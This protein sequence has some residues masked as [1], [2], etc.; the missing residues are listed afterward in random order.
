MGASEPPGRALLAAGTA[1][2]DWPDFG[3]LE[4]VPASLHAIVDALTGLGF[5]TVIE[6]PGYRVDPAPG[7]LRAAVRQAAAAAP[8]VVLYYTGHGILPERDGYYLV[9][10]RTRLTDM[11][12]TAMPAADIPRLLTRRDENGE[13][14]DDQP[15]V[16]VILDCCYSGS[17]GMEM[18]GH[19]LRGIG[20][21][22][23]W[24]IASVSAL[25]YA[26]QGR[27]A[28]AFCDAI[29]R[30][31][32]G[33]STR[34]LSLESVIQ[35]VNDAQPGQPEQ[36]ARVFPP[37]TG[38]AGI[39]P[40]F[41]NR[42]YWPGLAGLTVSEQHWLSRVRG[43]PQE[44]TTG[45]YLTGRTGR[46]RAAE[47][48]ATWMTGPDRG[49]LALV[50]GSPGTG[51][52]AL[53]A[54]PVLL[55]E[56]SRRKDLLSA[57]EHGSLIRRAADLLPAGTP[58]AAVHA[59]GLNTDQAA[60]AIAHALGR[61]ASTAST[62]LEELDAAPEVAGR[63]VV[64][65]AVDES[66]SPDTLL[67]TLLLPLSRQR[68]LRVAAGSRRHVLSGVQDAELVIDL[69]TPGYQDPQA[70]AVYVRRLLLAAEEPGVI[71]PYQAAGEEAT[72]AV[73]T[74]IAQRAMSGDQ[75]TESFLIGRFLALSVR[76]RA[77]PVDVT[78]P[79]WQAELPTELTDAFDEDLARLG[80]RTANAR[81]LLTALAWARGPGLPWEGIWTPVAR[82][83][84]AGT[85]P[86]QAPIT[87]E[88][89][90]WLLAKAGAYVVEDSGP[91]QRSVYRPFH[92]VLAAH[93][94]GEP[95]AESGVGD[96]ASDE[97][98]QQERAQI[99]QRITS[100]LLSTVPAGRHGRD[101]TSAHPYLRTYLAQHAAA[102]GTET[103]ADLIQ[104]AGFLAVAD[105]ATLSPY[106]GLNAFEEQDAAFFFGREDAASQLTERM[107][108]HLAEPGL[109]IVSGVSGSGKS[110]LL[111][112][113]VVP[114]IRRDGLPSAP[115]AAYWPQ[116][117][118]T[119]TRAPLDELAAR[120][121]AVTEADPGALREELRAD[122]ASLAVIAR[123][124]ARTR[125]PDLAGDPAV[126][127][128]GPPLR[129][130]LVIDQFEQL[131]TQC[132][133]E[134]QRLAFISALHS[135][136][137]SR[138]AVGEP[139]PALVVLGVR[140]DF[141]ARCADYPQLVDAVQGR[142]LVMPM[143]DLELRL[144]IT[145]PAKKAG[146]VVADDLVEVLLAEV[147]SRR[148]ISRAGVLP[149]LSHALDQA[150]RSRTGD[151]LTLADYERAGGVE[152]AVAGSAQRAYEGLTAGQQ[153]AARR[154]LLRL[155]TTTDDGVNTADRVARTELTERQG[156]RTGDV[157]AVLEAFTAEGLLTLTADSV[158]ITHEV[159][160]TAWPLL[161]DGWLAETASDRVVRARLSRAAAEWG[162]Q[163]R[164]P[165][166]LYSGSLLQAAS[167]AVRRH[168]GEPGR[169]L[170]LS[171]AEHDFIRASERARQ[172]TVRI[173][174]A[175]VAILAALAVSLGAL[176][177]IALQ[178]RQQSDRLQSVAFS[179]E[180][181]LQSEALAEINP[182]VARQ[183]SVAAW[184]L[185]PSSQAHYAML[186]A[187]TL[188]LTT[189]SALSAA[190]V[191]A[192]AFSPD[193]QILATAAANG[194]IRLWNVATHRPTGSAFGS[195][196]GAPAAKHNSDGKLPA[197]A[198]INGVAFSPDGRTLASADTSGSISLWDV[199]DPARPAMITVLRA[200]TGKAID[201]IA[202][203]PAGEILASADA[204]G[205][206]RL[207]NLA[208]H[209]LTG[210]PFGTSGSIASIAFSPDGKTLAS[211]VAD[212]I[213]IWNVSTQ[214]LTG[215][216]FGTSGSIA[217]IA[218]SPNGKTLA[219]AS[220]SDT[221]RLWNVSTRQQTGSVI[222]ARVGP[223][224]SVAF[225]HDGQTLATISVDGTA[226]LWDIATGNQI[227]QPLYGRGG[228]VFSIAFS[229]N[230]RVLAGGGSTSLSF[231]TLTALLDPVPALCASAGKPLTPA[232][233]ARYAPGI[234]YQQA[235][236]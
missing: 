149:L 45:F 136:A 80:A 164:V 196:D 53:L 182:R 171:Q 156:A 230:G 161:R 112:A 12:A 25:E 195:G 36:K 111:R 219:S 49:G 39:P 229:P 105:Q 43:A 17:A 133:D 55:A 110:S 51:K 104:D 202:F 203:S 74:V 107:A 52:S 82:A 21:P 16:L 40:F 121:A 135:A 218:F 204:G 169:Y 50:T 142:Y 179:N 86:G 150:W 68:G 235:C 216:P 57:A 41:P 188:P 217:S 199:T 26:Q 97:R 78:S 31:T 90:R 37:A 83:V 226:Q 60:G 18:L 71:T 35:A 165:E 19:A 46:V 47:D 174:Q 180:L 7:E 233:W 27:F 146:S 14:A 116:V 11:T 73:A 102:A 106:R 139:P 205:A 117:L 124:A 221:V 189:V 168:Q 131:F 130:L 66:F 187:T 87:D 145:E 132:P 101:W 84:S 10:R 69:D 63:V 224:R 98:W 24:V 211:A 108:A 225:S 9:N 28:A 183:L 125:A 100:A 15:T 34:F 143:T 210:G 220:A 192:V 4:K 59:R 215:A 201:S 8:I 44:S 200:G 234:P 3:N 213:L 214:Q 115:E 91:G 208:T 42:N 157:D 6:S 13:L 67:T 92:D 177:V 61:S 190:P 94:R 151:A 96:L 198:G 172:R 166:Y 207:W 54:L 81:A 152:G 176:T 181:A 118:L 95:N 30:P 154:I 75:R 138:T 231:W 119:P 1:V 162:R 236:P 153:G 127:D 185:N 79:G 175:A 38:S 120:V 56:P 2:Y 197:S 109:M 186:A 227:G 222:S 58:V 212:A 140:A 48:L 173:R 141:E 160:L 167:E 114:L 193:G 148:G 65:D 103:F 178:Q 170:P 20:N 206:I 85:G 159:L 70:L 99:E 126:A 113:G 64:V 88:D 77:E 32:T 22:N 147:R 134:G 29:L 123:E 209:R 144:A 93:L 76:G 223:A 33:P 184:R 158:E 232:E 128:S 72:S 228:P 122:P 163:A 5:S 155:I 191:S 137:T 89:V 129:M 62:L 23:T 194:T